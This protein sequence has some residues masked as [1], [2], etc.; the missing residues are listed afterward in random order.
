MIHKPQGE[1]ENRAVHYFANRHHR[2]EIWYAFW[3]SEGRTRFTMDKNTPGMFGEAEY[4]NGEIQILPPR[5]RTSEELAAMA[6]QTEE[7]KKYRQELY[8]R[9]SFEARLADLRKGKP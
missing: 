2:G 4:H 7:H 3:D 8:R 9:Y 1:F 6:K 5:E